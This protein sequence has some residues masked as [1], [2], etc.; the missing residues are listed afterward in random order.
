MQSRPPTIRPAGVAADRQS[1]RVRYAPCLGYQGPQTTGLQIA[2]RATSLSSSMQQAF[3]GHASEGRN[4]RRVWRYD[5]IARLINRSRKIGTAGG[6]PGNPRDVGD[7]PRPRRGGLKRITI[8][9]QLF[10]EKNPQRRPDPS[11]VPPSLTSS[12]PYWRSL[13]IDRG[14]T[15]SGHHEADAPLPDA[16][17]VFNKH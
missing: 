12:N 4:A 6:R 13:I 8:A 9:H 16:L 2:L 7:W 10:R 3:R 11:E 17:E 5:C 1:T 14:D 15:S